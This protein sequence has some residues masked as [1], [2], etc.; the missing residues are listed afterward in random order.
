MLGQKHNKKWFLQQSVQR[1]ICPRRSFQIGLSWQTLF[2][3]FSAFLDDRPCESILC[4][5]YFIIIIMFSDSFSDEEFILLDSIHPLKTRR[6]GVYE[7]DEKSQNLVEY[8]HLLEQ[9]KESAD[10][11]ITKHCLEEV[12]VDMK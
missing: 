9:M 3:A 2:C 7:K 11:N 4:N 6:I 8:N 5:L 10:C 12:L 1:I